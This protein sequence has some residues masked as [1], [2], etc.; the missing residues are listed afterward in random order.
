MTWQDPM[1]DTQQTETRR[2]IT[3][4][5]EALIDELESRGWEVIRNDVNTLT[6]GGM[7]LTASDQLSDT[8]NDVCYLV[9][10][11]NQMIDCT[12]S[13]IGECADT[14]EELLEVQVEKSFIELNKRFRKKYHG[15]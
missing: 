1:K 8:Y 2:R 11:Y 6:V 13:R 15:Y 4:I 14:I 9:T 10:D 5:L 3:N 7:T 12:L